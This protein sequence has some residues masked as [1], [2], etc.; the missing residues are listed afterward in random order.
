MIPSFFVVDFLG[1]LS[2][3]LGLT[4]LKSEASLSDWLVASH[5]DIAAVGTNVLKSFEPKA[6]SVEEIGGDTNGWSVSAN[7]EGGL[8]RNGL[9]KVTALTTWNALDRTSFD[10]LN[11]ETKFVPAIGGF[12]QRLVDNT[13]SS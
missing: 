8:D 2:V 11:T 10:G 1:D 3:P 7:R 4:R 13:D 12:S 5:H 9:N 6:A